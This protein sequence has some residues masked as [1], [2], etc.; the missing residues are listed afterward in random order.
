RGS[1]YHYP[2]DSPALHR[3]VRRTHCRSRHQHCRDG[4]LHGE[5]KEH[6]ALGTG[7]AIRMT[8]TSGWRGSAPPRNAPSKP[9]RALD[10]EKK[11]VLVVEDERDIGELVR[12]NLEQ[13][14]FAVIVA[15]DGEQAL[16]AMQR[17]RP[18]LVI[19]DLMLPGITG[20]EI[21]RR[22]RSDPATA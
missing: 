22:L 7:P 10:M 15:E 8:M 12:F 11:L 14:G 6:P 20:L 4:R 2:R 3:Q 13:D 19:L 16:A 18:V 17:Q 1:A 5:G 21:C 9:A